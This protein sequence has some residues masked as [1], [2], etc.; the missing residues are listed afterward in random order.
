MRTIVPCSFRCFPFYYGGRTSVRRR[1]NTTNNDILDVPSP[2]GNMTSV[3]NGQGRAGTMRQ[4]ENPSA[5]IGVRAFHV[6]VSYRDPET[7]GA[8]QL[9]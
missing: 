4:M 9:S 6:R 3:H 7:D 2:N 5:C 1:A 8:R